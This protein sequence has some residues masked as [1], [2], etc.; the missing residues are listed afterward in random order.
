MSSVYQITGEILQI[1]QMIDEIDT[2]DE[3]YEEMILDTL[4]GVMGEF[5]KKADSY[6]KLIRNIESDIEGLKKEKA[7]FETKIR[8]SENLI[9]TLKDRILYCMDTAKIPEIQGDTFKFKTRNFAQQLPEDIEKY[10][11]NDIPKAY[12]VDQE[13][14]LDKRKLLA[15]IKSKKI[16]IKGVELRTPRS[17]VLS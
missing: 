5:E 7:R 1:Y 17:A 11:K 10:H 16:E 12:W 6:G 14:K 8:R 9:K 2:P 4:E 13:P 3:E 15:D